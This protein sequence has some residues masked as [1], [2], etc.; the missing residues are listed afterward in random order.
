MYDSLKRQI[1]TVLERHQG[2]S[3]AITRR[4]LRRV[5]EIPLSQDRQLRDLIAE[6]RNEGIPVIFATERPQGYYIPQ[7]LTELKEGMDNLRKIIINE[8]I[9]LRNLKVKGNQYLYGQKQGILL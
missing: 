2:R 7:D 5:L 1:Q 8:C 3:R 4:E 9:T 6:M